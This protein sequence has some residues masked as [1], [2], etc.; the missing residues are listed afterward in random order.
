MRFGWLNRRV[1]KRW[2]QQQE[3]GESWSCTPTSIHH[4]RELSSYFAGVHLKTKV[5]CHRNLMV[6][7]LNRSVIRNWN[8]GDGFAFGAEHSWLSGVVDGA[9]QI[10]KNLWVF[11]LQENSGR[12]DRTCPNQGV[13]NYGKLTENWQIFVTLDKLLSIRTFFVNF[14]SFWTIFYQIFVV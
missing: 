5:W 9:P 3:E 14:L 2:R 1:W 8:V 4:L 11:R 12:I 10:Y 7:K 6:K 13:L